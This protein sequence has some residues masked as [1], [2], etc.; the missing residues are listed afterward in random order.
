MTSTEKYISDFLNKPT[1]FCY[2]LDRIVNKNPYLFGGDYNKKLI[3][4]KLWIAKQVY[5][6]C[7]PE[8]YM[9]F[10]T[11]KEAKDHLNKIKA[12]WARV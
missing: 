3:N 12:K 6:T 10:Y 2:I 9:Y 8:Q 5:P 4:K 1:Y 11:F 7:V